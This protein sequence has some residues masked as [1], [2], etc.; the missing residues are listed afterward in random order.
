[1]TLSIIGSGDWGS[2]LIE[3]FNEILSD[4]IHLVYGLL[5]HGAPN[6]LLFSAEHSNQ[7]FLTPF[8]L[9]HYDSRRITTDSEEPA[10]IAIS[11]G[12]AKISWMM[13]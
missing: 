6:L 12:L 5:V 4:G 10:M 3:K 11:F 7:Y 8:R 2:I 1:M 13:V 9:G